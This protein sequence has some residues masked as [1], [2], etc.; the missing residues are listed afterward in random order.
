MDLLLH[1]SHCEG[2]G[3]AVLEA[4]AMSK[5]V[6]AYAVG[7]IPELVSPGENGYL[8]PPGAISELRHAVE[9]LASNGELRQKMGPSGAQDCTGKVFRYADGVRTPRAVRIHCLRCQKHP[10]KFGDYK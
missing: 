5:P 8:V 10:I 7:G 3:M 2:F 6:V 4:M 9:Q 1:S